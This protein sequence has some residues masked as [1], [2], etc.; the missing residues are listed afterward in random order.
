MPSVLQADNSD[1]LNIL[2]KGV[3]GNNEQLWRVAQI[4]ERA[5]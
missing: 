2:E 4:S 5:N 3:F 1:R